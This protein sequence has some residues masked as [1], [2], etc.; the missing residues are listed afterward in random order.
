MV[1]H[2]EPVFEVLE[3][4]LLV[5]QYAQHAQEV[6]HREAVCRPD[7]S[8]RSSA[9]ADAGDGRP[10]RDGLEI[11]VGL[12]AAQ[13]ET[14]PSLG[15]G[16]WAAKQRRRWHTR[17]FGRHTRASA[18]SAEVTTFSMSNGT[19]TTSTAPSFIASTATGVVIHPLISS[20]GTEMR[21][22]FNSTM[23][24]GPE[25][26]GRQKSSNARANRCARIAA[27][28][29]APFSASWT[30]KLSERKTSP[31]VSRVPGSSS[32]TRIDTCGD[33]CRIPGDGDI[34]THLQADAV[35]LSTDQLVTIE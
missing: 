22:R 30:L 8:S 15:R 21:C 11:V 23:I 24:P 29:A 2:V 9:V 35:R 16:S 28:A 20:H 18:P 3:L 13:H 5:E 19:S 34:T 26:S 32:T 7:G 4:A 27:I 6:A 17:P 1:V 33:E 12:A 25:R 31:A 14:G 10:I